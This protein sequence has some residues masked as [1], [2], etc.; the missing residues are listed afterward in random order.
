MAKIGDGFFPR[1]DREAMG[2]R[3]M[4]KSGKLREDEPHPVALLLTATQFGN[5][6]RV[7]RL[8][9]IEETLEIE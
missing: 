3:A 9:R 2:H 1:G 7:D 5:D 4:S 8:L 6:S